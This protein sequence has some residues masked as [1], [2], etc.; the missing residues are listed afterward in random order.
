MENALM[1]KNKVSNLLQGKNSL[2]QSLIIALPD[3][4]FNLLKV[5]IFKYVYKIIIIVNLIKYKNWGNSF[6][7]LYI[8][9]LYLI[10]FHGEGHF[11]GFV[12]FKFKFNHRS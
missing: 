8:L 11:N 2:E 12:K 6:V 7:R 9:S 3:K 10:M 1:I 4:T 5:K